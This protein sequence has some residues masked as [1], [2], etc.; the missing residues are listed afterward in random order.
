MASG[1]GL[2]CCLRWASCSTIHG[3][4]GQ[5]G[6]G[7]DPKGRCAHAV[8]LRAAGSCSCDF[9]ISPSRPCGV[10]RALLGTGSNLGK[11]PGKALSLSRPCL[12]FSTHCNPSSGKH[13]VGPGQPGGHHWLPCPWGYLPRFH[14]Q[15]HRGDPKQGAEG[16]T[17]PVCILHRPLLKE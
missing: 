11:R 2:A 5:P 1:C 8:C 6:A 13:K 9:N 15:L 10:G 14:Q 4:G 12:C 16:L 7:Q 3:Q 17:Q